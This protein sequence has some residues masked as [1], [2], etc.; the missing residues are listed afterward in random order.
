[1]GEYKKKYIT[2]ELKEYLELVEYKEKYINMKN[3]E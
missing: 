1:M 3:G 2:I